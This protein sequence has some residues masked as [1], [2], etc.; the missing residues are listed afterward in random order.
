VAAP[1]ETSSEALKREHSALQSREA[2]QTK[3]LDLLTSLP[4]AEAQHV[5]W[6]LRS[7][8]PADTIYNQVTAGNAL[9]ELAVKPESWLRHEL[10]YQAEMPK[11]YIHNNP[12]LDTVIYQDTSLYPRNSNMSYL[13][14][15]AMRNAIASVGGSIHEA[16][17]L[18]PFHAAHVV[19]PLLNEAKPSLWTVVCKDDVLMRNI[20][21]AWLLCEYSFTSAFQKD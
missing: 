14:S 4:E 13:S 8:T 3:I 15:S 20:L 2:S 21:G 6:R 1:D 17:Y 18:M 10:L 9:V 7:G 11:H 19:H 16:A 5:L 12:Y